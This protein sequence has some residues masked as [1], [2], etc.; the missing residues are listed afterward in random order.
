MRANKI[1]AKVMPMKGKTSSDDRQTSFF[2]SF[3]AGPLVHIMP[4][5]LL[6]QL[7]QERVLQRVAKSLQERL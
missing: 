1:M 5:S 4:Q 6:L 3:F 2:A 7:Q